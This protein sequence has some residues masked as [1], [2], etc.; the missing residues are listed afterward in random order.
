MGVSAGCP[1]FEINTSSLSLYL[2]WGETGEMGET[3]F[4]QRPVRTLWSHCLTHLEH[5]GWRRMGRT[6]G[7]LGDLC[8]IRRTIRINIPHQVVK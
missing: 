8:L 6:L 2:Y 4:S 3:S 1:S 7:G 5:F